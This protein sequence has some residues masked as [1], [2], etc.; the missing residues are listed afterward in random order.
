M[1][2]LVTAKQVIDVE[3][4]LQVKEKS[5]LQDGLQHVMNAWDE[6]AVESAVMMKEDKGAEIS[7]VSIGSE[8]VTEV[9]RKAL[10]MGA[11]KGI[12]V[13]TSETETSDSF[14]ISKILQK[15]YEKEHYNLVI[16]GRQAQDTDNGQ[17]GAVFSEY[18]DLPCVTN[19]VGIEVKDEK[20]LEISRQGDLGKEELTVTL[21]AV[22]TVSDGINEPRLPALRG[23]MQAKKKPI[24]T[25]SLDS[26]GISSDEIGSQASR[27]EV[28]EQKNPD[29]RKAG[30]KFEGDLSEI[31]KKVV[32][33]L[34]NEAKVI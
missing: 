19:V 10:A 18:V 24:E 26:L 2:I 15:V 7:V 25:I 34:K 33:L 4:N 32:D 6:N 14:V 27:Y 30:Q 1:K 9:I 8:R 3:L 16:M 17:I 21:P 29:S 22:L 20:T 31:T 11:D 5:L 13:N 28:L 23:I 12:H